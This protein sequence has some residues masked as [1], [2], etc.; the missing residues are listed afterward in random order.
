MF[1][2]LW[3]VVLCLWLSS[4]QYFREQQCLYCQGPAVQQETVFW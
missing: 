4:S 2:I 3:D 1:Q